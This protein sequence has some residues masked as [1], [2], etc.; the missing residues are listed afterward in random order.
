MDQSTR[1]LISWTLGTLATGFTIMGVLVNFVLMPY[2]REHLVNPMKTVEKQVTENHH[3]NRLPTVLDRLDDVQNE[4]KSLAQQMK[5]AGDEIRV[6]STMFEGHISWSD[7]WVDLI[8][9]ELEQLEQSK[10]KD[11]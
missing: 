5:T 11:Q 8:E 3:S 10:N 1:E 6:M 7:R 2:L 9:R 4:V